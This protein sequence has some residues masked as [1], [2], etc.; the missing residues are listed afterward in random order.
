MTTTTSTNPTTNA[1]R[2]VYVRSPRKNITIAYK[3]DDENK[4]VVF[5]FA[6][7]SPRDNFTRERG[8]TVASGRLLSQSTKHPNSVVGYDLLM[9]E[10]KGKVSYKKIAGFL[11]NQFQ[12]GDTK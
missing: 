1:V 8:R 2:F 12:P 10:A 5:N 9:D 6:K 11:F 3:F 7:C 4:A